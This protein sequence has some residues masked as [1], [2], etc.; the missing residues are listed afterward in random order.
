MDTVPMTWESALD[1]LEQQVQ[2][3]ERLV[4][5]P[6]AAALTDWDP[7]ADLGPLPRHL[8]ARA[9]SLVQRQQAVIERIPTLL[10]T[11]RQQLHV[12]R[13]I[14]EA[15]TRPTSPVYIDVSA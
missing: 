13:R 14:G 5:S 12:G 10:Q 3:A 15:T 4:A 8:V 1:E 9:Q 7:P 2:R 6:D 11:T